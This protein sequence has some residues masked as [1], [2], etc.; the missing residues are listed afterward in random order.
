MAEPLTL[1][2]FFG[3]LTSLLFAGLKSFLDIMKH[4]GFIAYW[5]VLLGILWIDFNESIPVLSAVFTGKEGGN[6]FGSVVSIF[7]KIL[8]GFEISSFILFTIVLFGGCVY[9]L[10]TSKNGLKL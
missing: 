1:T 10:W 2:A 8:F 6:F 5:L 9:L 4:I 7:S 3:I